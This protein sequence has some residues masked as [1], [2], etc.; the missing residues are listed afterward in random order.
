DG[1]TTRR[2]CGTG[3]GLAISRQLIEYMGGEVGLESE[4]KV[5]S[6]FWFEL[7]LARGTRTVP[8]AK[9]FAP[10]K[11]FG[12]AVP[13]ERVKPAVVPAGGLK[14]LL[15]EDNATNQLVAQK[16]L[17][18]LGHRVD[19][20]GNGLEALER[21]GKQRY[22]AVLMDCQMPMLDGYET[23]RRIR[24]GEVEGVDPLIPIIALTAHALLDDRLKCLQAGMSDYV[25]K[26]VRPDDL[27]AALNRT[28]LIVAP[29]APVSRPDRI[30][31]AAVLDD[32][33]L[34]AFRGLPGRKGPELIPELVAMFQREEPTLLVECEGLFAARRAELLAEVAHKLAGSCASLGALEMSDAALALEKAASA[35]TWE[36]VPHLLG[37]LRLA[38][39][40]LH[41]AL[42][43]RKFTSA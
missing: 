21:L 5:G 34:A 26:P 38:S 37:E 43:D 42:S 9:P 11:T 6:S 28:G 8:T 30:G 19:I 31:S 13:V 17:E 40:R 2:F 16:L 1:S 36:S 12:S 23:T 39:R 14:L 24:S 27:R 3:L 22:N 18:K 7:E 41:D 4:P 29:E 32:S 10:A 15:A 25:S 35:S 33:V 20:V